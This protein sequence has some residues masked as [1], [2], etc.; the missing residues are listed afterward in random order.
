MSSFTDKLV[1]T[2]T[3]GML[4]ELERPFTY[5][6]GSEDSGESVTVP[7]DFCTDFASIPRIFWII[8]PPDGNY[9]QASVLHDYMYQ[10]QTFSRKKCDDIFLESM[11][12]LEVPRWKRYV[13]YRA[14]R[15][16]GWISWNHKRYNED[17]W[18]VKEKN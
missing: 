11:E 7:K 12:V 16:F 9:S 10:K 18:V 6:I 15:L 5:Y 17:S 1:V 4:W 13:M 3:T 14:L 2:K 8:L